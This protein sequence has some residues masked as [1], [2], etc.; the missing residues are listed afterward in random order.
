[1][2]II[3]GMDYLVTLTVNSTHF[4]LVDC[5]GGK[6]LVDAGWDLPSFS[7]Q[8]KARQVA[9]TAIRY[10]MFT[11]HH[12][13]HAGLAQDIKDLCGAK[14]IIHPLQI[15]YLKNLRGYYAKKGGYTPIRIEKGDLVG[16]DR[17]ALAAIGVQG[18]IVETPGHSPDSISLALD[19]RAAF[20][21]DLPAPDLVPPESYE[22][23]AASWKKLLGMGVERF[24]HGHAGLISAERV[25]AAL[26]A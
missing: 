21:G 17:A 26:A 19:S 15:P 20:I 22:A 12:P 4:Y 18:E 10:V 11:H 9:P 6:L 14:L 13:D 1:M 24:Y 5:Q 8:M 2:S 25:R 3:Q 7:A 23:T 16:P